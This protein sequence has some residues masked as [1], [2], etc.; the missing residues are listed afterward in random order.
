MQVDGVNPMTTRKGPRRA[1]KIRQLHVGQLQ[2]G[3]F[4]PRQAIDGVGLQK[5]AESIRAEGLLQPL[6]V[7]KLSRSRYEIIAGERR[8][9]AAKMAGLEKVPAVVR[10]VSDET[11][12]A[13]ALVENLQREDLNPIDQAFAFKY[14]VERF[15]MTHQEVADTVGLSRAS[16]TN[17]LR[18]LELPDEVRAMVVVGE[19]DMGHARAL[20]ALPDD[21]RLAAARRVVDQELSVRDVERMAKRSAS[22]EQSR[23]RSQHAAGVPPH[24][25][26]LQALLRRQSGCGIDI[27]PRRGGSWALN[28]AFAD[29][30]ELRAAL[31]MIDEVFRAREQG[32]VPQASRADKSV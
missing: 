27:K 29:L 7:R 31:K 1:D 6:F 5:L 24:L 16:V 22:Q 17:L 18:L 28:I 13:I 32:A 20:L 26:R 25:E 15:T 8:W 2:R 3:S 23:P 9:R 19:L 10:N 21:E 4:Q 12:L 14:L 11:A 30:A